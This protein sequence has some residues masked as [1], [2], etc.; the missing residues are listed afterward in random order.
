[1]KSAS[2]ISSH[3]FESQNEVYLKNEIRVILPGKEKTA[4]I[5]A[6]STNRNEKCLWIFLDEGRKT[7]RQWVKPKLPAA[8]SLTSAIPFHTN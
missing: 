5:A 7:N 2:F 8:K 6:E 1:M 4:D 3:A